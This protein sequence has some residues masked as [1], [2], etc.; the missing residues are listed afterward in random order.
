MIRTGRGFAAGSCGELVQGVLADGQAFQVSL[1]IAHGASVGVRCEDSDG[2]SVECDPGLTKLARSVRATL[3]LLD[4]GPQRVSVRRRSQLPTGAG[5]GSSTADI[6]AA[7]RAVAGAFGVRLTASDL[8]AVAGGIEPTDGAMYRGMTL[9]RRRGGAL[10]RWRWTPRFTA[11]VLIPDGTVGTEA[12]PAGAL[13]S[14][15][16][17]AAVDDLDHASVR[18]D[19]RPFLAAARLSAGIHH[20]ILGNRWAPCLDRLVTEAGALGAA[21]AH[22]GTI[23]G[24]LYEPTPDGRRAA[25]SAAAQLGPRLGLR[26]LLTTAG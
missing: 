5:M 15:R 9:V 12:V 13:R 8:A 17:D 22:T 21:V 6:V 19:R 25:R 14:D 3:D 11:L 26:T 23:A 16:Y 18:H 20:E 10:R 24:L 1:P 4:A 2:A 7:A